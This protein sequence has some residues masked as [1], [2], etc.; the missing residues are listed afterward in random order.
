MGEITS[1]SSCSQ[2]SGE[3]ARDAAQSH[4]SMRDLLA[5]FAEIAKPGEGAPKIIVALARLC[6][7]SWY[8]GRLRVEISG[9]D[10]RTTIE[11]LAELGVGIVERLLPL[12][13]LEVA[14]DEFVRAIDLAPELMLPLRATDYE[15]KLVLTPLLTPEESAAAALPEIE[16]DDRS[17]GDGERKTAPPPPD[18]VSEPPPTPTVDRP[19]FMADMDEPPPAA[20]PTPVVPVDAGA[21]EQARIRVDPRR[22]PD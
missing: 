12:T 1:L 16:L 2:L 22:E 14:F 17:L 10:A 8:D 18:A 21:I 9:D 20:R 7:Q 3:L 19:F 11:I 5:R 4:A 13:R 6:E 15:N